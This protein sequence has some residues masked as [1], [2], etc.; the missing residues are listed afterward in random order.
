[1]GRLPEGESTCW[2]SSCLWSLTAGVFKGTDGGGGEHD[3][4]TTQHQC[5]ENPVN[6]G[7]E[8]EVKLER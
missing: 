2:A 3:D 7:A 8:E 5:G 4:D 1:M 6:E